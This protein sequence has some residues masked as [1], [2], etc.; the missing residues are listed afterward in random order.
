LN[1]ARVQF[2]AMLVSC[3]RCTDGYNNMWLLFW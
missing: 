1:P 3:S 2:F